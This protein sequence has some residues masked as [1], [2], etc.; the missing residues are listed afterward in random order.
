MAIKLIKFLGNSV[1]FLRDTVWG[2]EVDDDFN[3]F[4]SIISLE[5]LNKALVM[6]VA[7]KIIQK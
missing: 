3:E 6:P 7:L 2:K 4:V 1:S 5:L